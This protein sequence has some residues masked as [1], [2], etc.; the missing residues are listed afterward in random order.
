MNVS[1]TAAL[2]FVCQ[3]KPRFTPLSGDLTALVSSAPKEKM[4]FEFK[5]LKSSDNLGRL[6]AV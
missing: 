5:H 3:H 6:A 4:G 2:T 1:Y